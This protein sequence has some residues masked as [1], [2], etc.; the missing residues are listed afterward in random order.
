MARAAVHLPDQ[1]MAIGQNKLRLS[2]NRRAPAQIHPRMSGPF[3]QH[4]VCSVGQRQQQM[5]ACS[6]AR[7]LLK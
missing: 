4:R 6:A 5:Q 1:F 7:K 2:T 3:M